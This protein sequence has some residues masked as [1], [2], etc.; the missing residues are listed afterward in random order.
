[1]HQKIRLDND[2]AHVIDEET[3]EAL[4][5]KKISPSMITGLRDGCPARWVSETFVIRDLIQE[6]DNAARRGQLFHSVME[7]F[8]VKPAEERTHENMRNIV[9]SVLSSEMYKDL[10]YSKEVILWLRKAVNGYFNMGIENP[11]EVIIAEIERKGRK[12]K[13][14]EVF[15]TG[16]IGDTSRN[17]LGFVDRIQATTSDDNS[18]LIVEDYKSGEKA[19]QWYP[20]IRYNEGWAE[21]RQQIIYS[22]LLEQDGENVESARLIYPVAG[23]V[24]TVDVKDQKLREQVITE[25]EETDQQLS[26]HI[27]TNTFEYNPSPLCAWCPLLK[28]CPKGRV[29]GKKQNAVDAAAG[30]PEPEQLSP[31]IRF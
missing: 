11:A 6:P 7:E 30:Q 9:R 25:V 14:L 26:N 27:A 15:V 22:I 8:Y 20:G 31:G 13:G 5:K 10:Q 18:L 1:M 29:F 2:G 12:N 3:G 17:T 16:K 21:Q 19:K 24:V 28:I 4:Q 23:E